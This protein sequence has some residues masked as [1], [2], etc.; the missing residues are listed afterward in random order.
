MLF[1]TRVY[2]VPCQESEG[3]K[4]VRALVL[5]CFALSTVGELEIILRA[6]NIQDFVD[7]LHQALGCLFGT[8]AV[9]RHLHHG[10]R[11]LG[12]EGGCGS[13]E[14]VPTAQ[15]TQTQTLTRLS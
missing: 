8:S 6:D 15:R 10:L 7:N 2:Y 11:A 3:V 4:S 9:Q 12:G 14:I 1:I 13:E 5:T